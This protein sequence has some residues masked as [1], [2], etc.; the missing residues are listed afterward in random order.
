M[1]GVLREKGLAEL[2]V[3]QLAIVVLVESYHKQ[4]YLVTSDLETKCFKSINQ[5]FDVS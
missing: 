5:V 1:E 2:T 3:A 4:S